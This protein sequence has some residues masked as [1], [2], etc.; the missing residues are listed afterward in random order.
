MKKKKKPVKKLELGKETLKKLETN[1]L[2]K[3]YGG[4]CLSQSPLQRSCTTT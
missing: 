3:V 1:T 4:L 2:E